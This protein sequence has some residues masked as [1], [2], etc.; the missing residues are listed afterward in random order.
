MVSPIVRPVTV[1]QSSARCWR[2]GFIDARHPDGKEVLR[3]DD[4]SVDA[5]LAGYVAVGA[6]QVG[7]ADV[8]DTARLPT[9]RFGNA[10]IIGTGVRRRPIR[11]AVG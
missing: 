4:A 8:G 7:P 1:M 5:D 6:F 3:Q 9:L 11:L 2:I 10:E